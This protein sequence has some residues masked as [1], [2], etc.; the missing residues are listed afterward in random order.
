MNF[1][2]LILSLPTENATA[3]QRIWRA[4]KSSGAA[5]LRDGVYLMPER[6]HCRAELESLVGECL[7]HEHERAAGAS[8]TERRRA[9]RHS[10]CG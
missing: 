1:I 2:A 9:G 8:K 10:T 5:V 3:R 6:E 7:A 4:L